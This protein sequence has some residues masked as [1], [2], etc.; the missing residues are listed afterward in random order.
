MR[1]RT[2]SAARVTL[3][4]LARDITV[5]AGEEIRTEISAKFRKDGVEDELAKAG[6]EMDSW[7]TDPEQRFALS[8]ARDR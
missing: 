3:W 4:E 2:T 5:Q 6:F 1:L 8:L 7:W